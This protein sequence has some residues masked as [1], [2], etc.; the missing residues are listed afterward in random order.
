MS[1]PY[2]SSGSVAPPAETFVHPTAEVSPLAHIGAGCSIWRQAHVRE[3][4]ELG[5][6]C[7]IGASVYVGAGV[8]IGRNCKVQ[9]QAL[10]YDG[11]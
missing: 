3:G 1:E 7:T 11:V 5:E 6:H 9:N 2:E 8:K 4:A 10:R